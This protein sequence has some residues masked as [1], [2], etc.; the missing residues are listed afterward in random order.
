MTGH[1]VPAEYRAWCWVDGTSALALEMRHVSRLELA[2]D[3]VLVRNY[4]A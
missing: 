1:E 2:D 3:E 4:V